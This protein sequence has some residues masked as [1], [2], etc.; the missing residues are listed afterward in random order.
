M[1]ERSDRVKMTIR[2]PSYLVDNVRAAAL[3]RGETPSEFIIRELTEATSP[4]LRGTVS[5]MKEFFKR[6]GDV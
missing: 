3:R 6:T 5:T 1:T 4:H 2:M